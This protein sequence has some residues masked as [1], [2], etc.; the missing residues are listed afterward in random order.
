MKNLFLCLLATWVVGGTTVTYAKSNDKAVSLSIAKTS[1]KY[2]LLVQS[3]KSLRSGIMT[4]STLKES[5]PDIAFEIVIM[6]QMVT[7]LSTD[8]DLQQAYAQAEKLG[9]H[10]VVCQFALDVYGVKLASLNPYIKSTAN[11]HLYMFE[12]QDQGYNTLSI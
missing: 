8:P 3:V 1:T 5:R 6:G 12:L 2:A 11:A 7:E 9:I 4:A 10:L